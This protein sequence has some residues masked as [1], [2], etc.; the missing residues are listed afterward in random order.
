MRPTSFLLLPLSFVLGTNACVHFQ[1]N[2]PNGK[3]LWVG[4]LYDQNVELCTASA[5]GSPKNLN[6]GWQNMPCPNAAAGTDTNVNFNIFS[7]DVAYTYTSL[8][9]GQTYN[10]TFATSQSNPGGPPGTTNVFTADPF[11]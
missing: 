8:L 6:N 11:C 1:V 4:T 5:G 10:W 7:G 3:G 2:W 9:D